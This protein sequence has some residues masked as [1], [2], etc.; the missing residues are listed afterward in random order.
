MCLGPR[1]GGC[2][3]G[4]GRQRNNYFRPPRGNIKNWVGLEK[5]Q[6]REKIVWKMKR[7]Q[8]EMMIR[9]RGLG[10]RTRGWDRDSAG[11]RCKWR[12]NWTT[13][14][15]PPTPPCIPPAPRQHKY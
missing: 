11:P 2:L 3:R 1:G 12:L 4:R 10:N 7:K 8:G 9:G 5:R 6:R 14:V 13:T 15:T